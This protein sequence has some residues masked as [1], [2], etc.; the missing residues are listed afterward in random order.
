[1]IE[2]YQIARVPFQPHYYIIAMFDL[3]VLQNI[4]LFKY[5]LRCRRI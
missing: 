4:G 5:Q 1:V 2:L 3:T